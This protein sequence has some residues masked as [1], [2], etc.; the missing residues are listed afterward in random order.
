MKPGVYW[1]L[2][3]ELAVSRLPR[4]VDVEVVEGFG[5]VIVFSTTLEYALGGFLPPQYVKSLVDNF[6]WIPTGEYNAPPLPRLVEA[7]AR[8]SKPL[9]VLVLCSR[10]CGRSTLGAIAWLIVYKGYRLVEAAS[11]VREKTMCGIET[12]PQESVLESLYLAHWAGLLGEVAG[13]TGD[14]PVPEYTLLLAYRLYWLREGASL[15]G[16][17]VEAYR[18]RSHPL[19]I[20][21]RVL[22]ESI[23]YSLAGVRV[24][25]SKTSGARVEFTI[26]I[27]RG[28]HPAAVREARTPPE[29]LAGRA[30]SLLEEYTGGAR[31]E[32]VFTVRKSSEPP[33][34]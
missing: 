19:N 29:S 12:M 9:P 8:A 10:G 26:W 17:A 11:L 22:A 31:V 23:G 25:G 24:R 3:G 21:A 6:V 1:V 18:S 2:E 16:E 14:D 15:P 33:W 27:P 20:L 34:L 7:L 28:S 13:K 5:T 32:T 4:V 30:L